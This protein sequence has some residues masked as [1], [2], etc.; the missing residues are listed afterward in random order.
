[1]EFWRLYGP[2]AW[3]NSASSASKSMDVAAASAASS[4]QVAAYGSG[5][6]VICRLV[7]GGVHSPYPWG[8]GGREVHSIR[9]VVVVG[10]TVVVGAAVV[11]GEPGGGRVIGTVI[12]GC[13]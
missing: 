10:G 9:V 4:L 7:G 13:G 2:A 3:M 1:M 6:G 8:L 5:I 12:T 11:V